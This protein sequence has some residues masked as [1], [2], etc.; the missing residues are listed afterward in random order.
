LTSHTLPLEGV[1]TIDGQ[2]NV[3]IASGGLGT[4]GVFSPPICTP[5]TVVKAD[6]A[7]QQVFSTGGPGTCGPQTGF[8]DL[9][10]DAGDNVYLTGTLNVATTGYTPG[11]FAAKLS[12]DGS[13][14]VY[15]TNLPAALAAPMAIRLDTQGN[16]YIAGRTID[17]HPFVTKLA[18]DG[19]TFV[20]SVQ[21]AGSGTSQPTP[22]EALA[23]T[24]DA[25]GNVL[26]TGQTSSSDFPVT[27]GV[28]Q[29][30]LAGA[31]S[32]FVARLDPT[33]KILFSTFLGGSGGANGQAIQTDSTGNIYVAG[34]AG[35][36]FPTSPDA[37]QPTALVP[38]WSTGPTAYVAKLPA[39]ASAIAWATYAVT[40]GNDSSLASPMKLAVSSAGDTYLATSTGAGFI[41]T[42]SAPQPCF[43]L[44]Y[45]VVLMHLSA[46]GVLADST[47]LGTSRGLSAALALPGDGSV[48]VAASGDYGPA[49]TEV[50][51]GQAGWTAPACLSPDVVNAASFSSG[52]GQVSPG[53]LVSLTGFGIGPDTGIGYQPGPQGQVPASLGG[54]Q[55]FVNGMAAPLLYTQSRQVNA[56]VPFEIGSPTNSPAKVTVTLTYGSATFGPYIMGASWMG[57]PGFFR[58]QPGVSTE[59][60]ALNQDG[61]VNGPS[62]PA[63]RG[64][65][66]TFY[67]T[68]YGPLTTPC[69]TGG[70]NPPMAV[71]LYWTGSPVA[72]TVTYEGSAP[73]LLCGIA[74]FNFQVPM[75]ATPGQL[76]LTPYINPGYGATIFI[77]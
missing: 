29:S 56:Q 22:D 76:L 60:A 73:A 24:L 17:Y 7:G 15:I 42:L 4:G 37:Y 77:R 30:K 40:N 63:S 46:Q 6:H 43:G 2:Q 3:Y 50:R 45:D 54:V 66:V 28:A 19:S 20:Y 32:A 57:P 62:N 38:L 11:G 18:A 59:A 44:A 13:K 27:A 14:F 53:E 65:I 25:A 51:F 61:T 34:D 12:A 72:Y 71:P 70:L 1:T 52:N 55:V 35:A 64:S 33:G 47:Y 5:M 68:G 10:V 26:V 39:D 8:A 9:A 21:F 69:A 48:L 49:V 74:Q 58:L 16:A 41:P 67:G 75:D 31:P 23:L 36:G